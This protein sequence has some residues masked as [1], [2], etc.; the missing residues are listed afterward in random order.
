MKINQINGAVATLS[1]SNTAASERA[2]D[3]R[4]AS[5]SRAPE[6]SATWQSTVSETVSDNSQD[7]D[8]ARVSKIREAIQNGEFKID[9][10]KI[11]DG[12]I[13]D[14]RRYLDQD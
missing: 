7:I 6:S 10:E 14:T 1:S 5:T 3:T 13:D 4:T 11:A 8:T 2:D 12:L 9:V